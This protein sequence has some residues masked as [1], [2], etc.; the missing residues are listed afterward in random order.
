MLLKCRECPLCPRWFS[1]REAPLTLGRVPKD[2]AILWAES[3]SW[4]VRSSEACCCTR[5]GRTTDSIITNG[6]SGWEASTL[7]HTWT[8]HSFT[9]TQDTE[10]YTLKNSFWGKHK[11]TKQE[12]HTHTKYWLNRLL[13][14]HSVIKHGGLCGKGHQCWCGNCFLTQGQWERRYCSQKNT[15]C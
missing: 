14:P 6:Q 15:L 2:R 13:E 12:T 8:V 11:H 10:V 7:V 4:P 3:D 1:G 9:Y 5:Q